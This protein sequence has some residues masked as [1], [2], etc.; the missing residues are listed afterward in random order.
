MYI[1]INTNKFHRRIL[2]NKYPRFLFVDLRGKFWLSNFFRFSPKA[3]GE[4]YIRKE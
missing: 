1:S 2:T 4:T 3:K